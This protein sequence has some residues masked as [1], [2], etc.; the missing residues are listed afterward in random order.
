MGLCQERW[1]CCKKD[2]FV[3]RKNGFV[4]RKDRFVVSKNGFVVRKNG[5]VVRKDGF[6]VRKIGFVVRK[7]G[8]VVRKD[9]LVVRKNGFVVRKDGFVVRK[10]DL[11]YE[12]TGLLSGK[13]SLF[14]HRL[15]P[16]GKTSYDCGK[17]SCCRDERQRVIS[18][19]IGGFIHMLGG[20]KGTCTVG[21]AQKGEL[22]DSACDCD[23]GLKCY[24]P[25]TGMCCLPSTCHDENYVKKQQAY[26]A[27]C[28]KNPNCAFPK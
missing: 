12:K 21:K 28:L 11:L 18:T 1:V 5:F 3:V 10:M 6:V 4:V 20:Q 2:G 15:C 26:W 23:T 17:G 13:I 7:D 16:P 25:M 19:Q 22:C 27:N 9:G 24:R 14:Q 8:I